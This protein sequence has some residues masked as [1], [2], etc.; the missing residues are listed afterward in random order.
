MRITGSQVYSTAIV[1]I[2]QQDSREVDA[3]EQEALEKQKQTQ[4]NA[5]RQQEITEKSN[6]IGV[7]QQSAALQRDVTRISGLTATSKQ[8]SLYPS[9]DK[10][11]FTTSQQRALDSYSEN[12]RIGG[13]GGANSNVEIIS[14]VD[15]FV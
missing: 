2:T 11:R 6:D 15:V 5:R 8:Y 3:R 9:P 4:E 14:A 13:A 1:P 12:Q 10:S 7:N